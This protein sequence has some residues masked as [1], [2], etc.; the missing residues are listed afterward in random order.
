M[1]IRLLDYKQQRPEPSYMPYS[2]SVRNRVRDLLSGPEAEFQAKDDRVTKLIRR[3][4]SS[5]S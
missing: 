5:A 3:R 1:F 2:W 4:R